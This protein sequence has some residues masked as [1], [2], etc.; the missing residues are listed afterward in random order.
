MKIISGQTD[1]RKARNAG[2]AERRGWCHVGNSEGTL[3]AQN[4]KRD[5]L[6]ESSPTENPSTRAKPRTENVHRNKAS[7]GPRHCLKRGHRTNSHWT[8][9]R[10]NKKLFSLE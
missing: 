5:G 4:N 9:K 6:R 2:A 1:R 8:L 7:Y 10:K 3:T